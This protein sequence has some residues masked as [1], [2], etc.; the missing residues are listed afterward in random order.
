MPHKADRV[1]F[2]IRVILGG[3]EPPTSSVS[4]RRPEPL[5][6]RI[7]WSGREAALRCD[8]PR[9]QPSASARIRTWNTA[10]E[11]R[12]DALFPTKEEAEGEGFDPSRPVRGYRFSKATRPSR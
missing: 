6:H 11:A 12:H 8:R 4:G 3:I 9:G 1:P 7:I 2:A 5:G 10:F